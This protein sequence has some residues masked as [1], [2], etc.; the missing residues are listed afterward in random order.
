MLSG[1]ISASRSALREFASCEAR[2]G[3]RDALG[4]AILVHR[5]RAN[6]RID[7]IAIRQCL[8]ERLEDDDAAA[9]AAHEA[10]G[11]GIEALQRPSGASIE[12]LA[13]AMV[14]SGRS[15]RFTPPANANS[16]SPFQMLWHARST[17]TSEDEHAVSSA[18]LGPTRLKK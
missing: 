7:P 14:V 1:A 5:R 6:E 10:V 11:A 16:L 13:A 17:A 12:A 8:R 4:A 3:N 15:I 2:L 9:F 18:R